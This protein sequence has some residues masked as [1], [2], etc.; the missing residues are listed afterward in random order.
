[1]AIYIGQQVA[2]ALAYAGDAPDERGRPLRLVHGDL[3]PGNVAVLRTGEIKVVGFGATRIVSF[4]GRGGPL[5][6]PPR[7]Q[8]VYLAPEQLAGAPA[9]ARSDLYSLGVML[10][11]LICSQPLFPTVAS[12]AHTIPTPSR[13]RP[14]VPPALDGLVMQMLEQA[15]SRR[16]KNAE[17]VRRALAALLPAP[18]DAGLALAA[19]TRGGMDVRESFS[20]GRRASSVQRIS[21]AAESVTG[22]PRLSRTA[23]PTA[24][25]AI[26]PGANRP[27]TR[28]V[29]ALTEM[30]RQG[31]HQLAR[32]LPGSRRRMTHL[33]DVSTP[34]SRAS[35]PAS[36]TRTEPRPGG[37]VRLRG[38]V[39]VLAAQA[40]LVALL[41]FVAGVVWQQMQVS[42][43]LPPRFSSGEPV[44]TPSVL[45]ERLAIDPPSELGTPPA[46]KVLVPAA[47][48]REPRRMLPRKAA[49]DTRSRPGR[50]GRSPAR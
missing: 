27:I 10:W 45:I 48:A 39:P 5:V 29:P 19:M 13:V 8:A 24:P 25:T 32:V 1:M 7:G 17:E 4:I 33:T 11:E 20:R 50:A 23:Q 30:L 42:P 49:P 40:A 43:A 37:L 44:R 2:S 16:R 9:D 41:A 28:V 15:P 22:G 31:G 3:R 21:P 47:A 38:R 34:V 18:A 14:D 6:P 12:T 46:V 36:A 35:G 26:R